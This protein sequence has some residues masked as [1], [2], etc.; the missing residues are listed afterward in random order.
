MAGHMRKRGTNSWQLLVHIGADDTGRRR[1][2]SKTVRSTKRHAEIALAEFV[3]ESA[4]G[5][6][7]AT[8]PISVESVVR[9]WLTA[10][11][12][13]LAASTVV[14]YEVAIK[15][16]GPSDRLDVGGATAHPRHRRLLR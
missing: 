11:A 13:R 7:V 1:Y 3:T 12:P 5:E 16:I 2:A 10:K 15:Q 4:K 8:G 14:R 6:L 9:A